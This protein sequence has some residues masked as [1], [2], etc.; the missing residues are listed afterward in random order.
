[1]KLATLAL[2]LALAA[3]T[4][5]VLGPVLAQ[6][7]ATEE[8]PS[9]AGESDCDHCPGCFQTH[10]HGQLVT[11]ARDAGRAQQATGAFAVTDAT[12]PDDPFAAPIDHPP[13]R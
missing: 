10:G 13:L 12:T 6:L 8:G 2:A 7:C 3:V 1:M 4:P 9:H 11:P 5:I